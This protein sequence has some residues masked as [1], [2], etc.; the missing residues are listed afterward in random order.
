ISE[1]DDY[2]KQICLGCLNKLEN[3]YE[4]YSASVRAQDVI[5][6]IMKCLNMNPREPE[7]LPGEVPFEEVTFPTAAS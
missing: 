2:P 1:T 6:R 3:S 7:K 4:L 5:K